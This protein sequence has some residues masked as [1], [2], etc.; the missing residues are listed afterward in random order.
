MSDDA[1]SR[2]P[3]R[4]WMACITTTWGR[5]PFNTSTSEMSPS[6]MLEPLN[7]VNGDSS[8]DTCSP[9]VKRTLSQKQRH[10]KRG[11]QV[12][13]IS[14]PGR[15][16]KKGGI[17]GGEIIWQKGGN[18]IFSRES[19]QQDLQEGT[20][21]SC[22]NSPAFVQTSANRRVPETHDCQVTASRRTSDSYSSERTQPATPQNHQ[23]V[24]HYQRSDLR[25]D[26]EIG[27]VAMQTNTTAVS[28]ATRGKTTGRRDGRRMGGWKYLGTILNWTTHGY[29]NDCF[30]GNALDSVNGM[31]HFIYLFMFCFEGEKSLLI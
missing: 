16:V 22:Y 12:K 30:L 27:P 21:A 9:H 24:E 11:V 5:T 25:H 7:K 23:H 31:L 19:L 6:Y 2:M 28:M 8:I 4:S 29:S 3:V 10:K 14:E 13:K 26:K 20:T 1:K 18:L 17:G 15:C